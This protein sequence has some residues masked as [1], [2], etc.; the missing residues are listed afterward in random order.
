MESTK[1]IEYM[2]EIFSERDSR[3]YLEGPINPQ[4]LRLQDKRSHHVVR[5]SVHLIDVIRSI[6]RHLL[7]AVVIP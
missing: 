3:Q 2:N 7:S 5:K 4:L 1:I 6:L